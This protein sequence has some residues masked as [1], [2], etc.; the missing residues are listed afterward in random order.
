MLNE[1]VLLVEQD[2]NSTVSCALVF[3]GSKTSVISVKEYNETSV[4]FFM[5]SPLYSITIEKSALVFFQ[6]KINIKY[7]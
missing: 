2:I 5:I 6:K 4:S 1:L 3:V 7:N